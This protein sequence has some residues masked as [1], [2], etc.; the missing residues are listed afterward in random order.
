MMVAS[1]SKWSQHL[2][3]SNSPRL[4]VNK[5]MMMMM[6]M[7]KSNI[8]VRKMKMKL[9]MSGEKEGSMLSIRKKRIKS[10]NRKLM[11]KKGGK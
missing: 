3:I 6:M 7:M 1:I 2:K 8:K 11:K 10:C 9:L 4:I 5:M